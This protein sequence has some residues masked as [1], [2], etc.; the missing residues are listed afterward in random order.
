MHRLSPCSGRRRGP[1]KLP[2]IIFNALLLLLLYR[3]GARL[4][5]RRVGLLAALLTLT[6]HLFFTLTIYTT[7]DL[8]FVV[9]SAAAIYFLYRYVTTA[10]AD[11]EQRGKVPPLAY[12]AGSGV[13]TGLMMLQKPSGAMIALGMGIWLLI[14]VFNWRA[15]TAPEHRLSTTWHSLRRVVVLA[16]VWTAIALVVLSP[17]L[18][19]NVALFGKPVYSTESYDAWVLGYRGDSGEAW[20][21]IYR[22]YTPELGGPGLPDRSWIL[23]WGFDYTYAKF[24]TQVQALREYLVPAWS[25]LP[26]ALAGEDG[27]LPLLSR[28][29]EKNLLTPAGIW[30]AW[31]GMVAALRSRWRLLSLLLLAFAPYTVFLLTYWRTNEERY[32]LMVMPWLYLLAAWM[33][34]AG[35]DRLSAIGQRRWSPLALILV[36]VVGTAIVQ[37]SW[38]PIA[39]K[40]QV[41]PQQWSPDVQAYRWIEEN[42]PPAT[43]IMTRNPW[44]L[45]WHTERP[46]VMIPNTA[47]KGLLFGLARHYEA[48]YLVFETLQRIKGDGAR[49]LAPLIGA[50]DAQV[51]DVIDG[52]EVVYAS[53]T[54][55]NRVL[56][57]RFPDS[58]VETAE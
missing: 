42:V 26:A 22:V 43:V 57:Y 18:A 19:R 49:T 25:G 51:G 20:H 9:F 23:R 35:Y 13:F 52:F 44:Q 7:S 45:N 16:G 11:A 27:Y 28:N 30:L 15:L 40:V 6:N 54:P 8:P 39:T 33:I 48:E 38:G 41:E 47:D 55:D 34:W 5:D 1:P 24:R 36:G 56:I 29:E 3:I 10:A 14:S 58:F 21:D 12:L 53:P 32:F 2:N 17:Y 37:P 46:A 31:I 50:A 4:W